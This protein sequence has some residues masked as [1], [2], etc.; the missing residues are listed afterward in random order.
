MITS[1]LEFGAVHDGKEGS[2]V[3]TFEN[4]TETATNFTLVRSR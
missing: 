3:G 4:Q 1:G 2:G